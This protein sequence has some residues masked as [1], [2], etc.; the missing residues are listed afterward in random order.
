MKAKKIFIKSL[1]YIGLALF[2][3]CISIP[4]ATSEVQET[5]CPPWEM[6]ERNNAQSAESENTFVIDDLHDES[7][8]ANIAKLIPIDALLDD[9]AFRGVIILDNYAYVT[10]RDGGYLLVYKLVD[11]LKS[12]TYLGEVIELNSIK[13]DGSATTI[14]RKDDY[15]YVGGSYISIIDVSTRE[16]PQLVGTIYYNSCRSIKVVDDYLIAL[17]SSGSYLFDISTTPTD[18]LY[19]NSFG[20]N[21]N[22]VDATIFNDCLY[23]AEWIDTQGIRIYDISEIDDIQELNYISLDDDPYHVDV[24]NGY[25]F[26]VADGPC[27]N[28]YLYSHSLSDPENPV[29]LDS[30][31]LS[32]SGRAFGI[33]NAF[34]VIAGSGSHNVIDITNPSSMNVIGNIYDKGGTRDEFPFDIAIYDNLILIGGQNYV[35]ASKV[36][37]GPSYYAIIVGV[38]D[39]PGIIDDLE[40][41]DDD[42]RDMMDALVNH[43]NWELPNIQLL[44]NSNATKSNVKNAIS[45][46]NSR[47]DENDVCL[48]FFSGHGTNGLDISPFDEAD[49]LDEYLCAYDGDIR[50]DELSS[51]LGALPTTNVIVILDTCFSGGHIRGHLD[52]GAR[53]KCFSGTQHGVLKGDGFATDFERIEGAKDMSQNPGCVVLT[54]TE[55]DESSW[56][57]PIISNGLFTYFAVAAINNFADWNVNGELSAEEVGM[58]IRLSFSFLYRRYPVLYPMLLQVPQ[59]YDDYPAGSSHMDELTLCI[60]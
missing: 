44:L 41:P 51:W 19:L 6:S 24:M 2:M 27:D 35:L 14:T 29:F 9:R 1:I 55:D 21:H 11:L 48:F 38:A 54:A 15:L 30:L 33:T 53:V 59:L 46:L 28:S 31:D 56:E 20:G 42:A 47:V 45:L 23:V 16:N 5:K 4:L 12:D 50:D 8:T 10:S 36:N 49:G 43:S 26:S 7:N 39:Y 22:N 13:I 57:F 34:C 18:P 32:V 52:A 40:F 3:L 17:G 58:A 60:P 25:L 37:V